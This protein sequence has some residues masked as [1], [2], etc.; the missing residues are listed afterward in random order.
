MT[1]LALLVGLASTL[2]MVG[3]IWFVQVVHYPLFARVGASDFA[4]YAAEHSAL[5][6][7]VVAPFMLAELGS[8][9]YLVARPPAHVPL[10]WLWLGLLLCGVV[11]TATGA[12]SVPQHSILAAG[13]DARAWRTL[14]LT[15]WVRTLAWSARGVLMLVVVNRV[16]R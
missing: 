2:A 1:R 5:T 13:F 9:L 8:A 14:V 7:W 11:W 4:A 3:L 10:A 15:N 12:L 6:T 16:M